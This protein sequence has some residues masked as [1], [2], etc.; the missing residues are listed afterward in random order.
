MMYRRTARWAFALSWLVL[1]IN[2][3]AR[4]EA[5]SIWRDVLAYFE[6]YEKHLLDDDVIVFAN[7]IQIPAGLVRG[8]C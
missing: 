8:R 2:T 6:Q 7:S 5:V 3:T 4:I 1:L